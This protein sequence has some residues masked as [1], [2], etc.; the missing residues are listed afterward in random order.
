MFS[1]LFCIHY[2]KYWHFRQIDHSQL[3]CPGWWKLLEQSVNPLGTKEHCTDSFLIL[4]LMMLGPC[5]QFSEVTSFP[6]DNLDALPR[7]SPNS[8]PEFRML[9]LTSGPSLLL[10]LPRLWVAPRPSVQVFIH[11]LCHW[12]IVKF[13]RWSNGKTLG[14]WLHSFERRLGSLCIPSHCSLAT[15]KW[16]T[17]S[18]RCSWPQGAAS[19]RPKPMY[20]LHY[21][22]NLPNWAKITFLLKCW[23]S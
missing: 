4:G 5:S 8:S 12:K 11:N 6:M 20:L 9:L 19:P 10:L 15:M 22:T 7:W 2:S 21:R 23:L 16:A 13:Q 14:H 18:S 17:C 3:L 1:L